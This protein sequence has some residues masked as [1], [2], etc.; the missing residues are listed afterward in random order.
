MPPPLLLL[1]LIERPADALK[2]VFAYFGIDSVDADAYDGKRAVRLLR[3]HLLRLT[4]RD[5]EHLGDDALELPRL[6]AEVTSVATRDRIIARW[7]TSAA[8]VPRFAEALLNALGHDLGR[9]PATKAKIESVLMPVAIQ[10]TDRTDYGACALRRSLASHYGDVVQGNPQLANAYQQDLER[11]AIAR[12]AREIERQHREENERQRNAQRDTER[13]VREADRQARV[14]EVASMTLPVRVALMLSG[15]TGVAGAIP[16][17]WAEVSAQ[18]VQALAPSARLALIQVL[19][20]QRHR[21]YREIRRQLQTPDREAQE[22]QRSALGKSLEGMSLLRQLDHLASAT[23]PVGK[24]PASLAERASASASSVPDDLR[25][26]LLLRLERQRRGV[27]RSLRD[28]LRR[29]SP[30]PLSQ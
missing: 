1:L 15:S 17:A 6:L 22:V 5:V 25:A 24:Y 16:M 3:P 2:R 13:Q 10:N 23:I 21:V 8:S 12:D 19:R 30:P 14:T 20:R 26:R 7:Y 11:E 9:H 28:A 29:A 4:E 27:W 18:E